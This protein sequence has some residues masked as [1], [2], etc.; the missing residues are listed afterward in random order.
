MR[1][2]DHQGGN[3]DNTANTD[4]DVQR[5]KEP[6]EEEDSVM[7]PDVWIPPMWEDILHEGDVLQPPD[8]YVVP[9]DYQPRLLRNPSLRKLSKTLCNIL[10]WTAKRIGLDISDQ[11]WVDVKKLLECGRLASTT[12]EDLWTICETDDKRRFEMQPTNDGRMRIRATNGHGIPGV[13]ALARKLLPTDKV[14]WVVHLTNWCAVQHIAREGLKRFQRNHIH[15][16]G[17]PPTEGETVAGV[18]HRVDFCVYVDAGRAIDDGISFW[19]TRNGVIVSQGDQHGKI[20]LRYIVKIVDKDTGRQYFPKEGLPPRWRTKHEGETTVQVHNSTERDF[21]YYAWCKFGNDAQ[22]VLM[23]VDTGASISIIPAEIYQA[24]PEEERPTLQEVKLRIEVGNGETLA[25]QGV[26]RIKFQLGDF[27]F[28]H[29]F[30]VCKDS[31]QAILGNE[32]LVHYRMVLRMAEGWLEYR[33]HC[34]PLFNWV[35]ARHR[36]KVFL[37]KTVQVPPHSEVEVPTEVRRPSIPG[38]PQVFEPNQ[39]LLRKANMIAPRMLF[40]PRDEHPRVRLFNP[41]DSPV[42]ITV[43]RCLGALEDAEDVRGSRRCS[44]AVRTHSAHSDESKEHGEE[45]PGELPTAGEQDHTT[46]E[47]LLRGTFEKYSSNIPEHMAGLVHTATEN[48]PPDEAMRVTLLLLSFQDVFARHE[49]DIGRTTLITHDVDTGDAKPVAQ[50]VRRQSP[51]EHAAMVDIVQTLHKCGIIQPSKSQWAANIRMARKKDKKWRMCIDYRDLNKR[52][53]I[54]DPYPLPRI[55]ALLD[56]LGRGTVFCALDLISGYHQVSMTRR[57]Q[58]KSAFITPQMSPSHW[59]YK[60]MP[61]GLTGAPATFQRLVD[62]M[63]RGIQYNTV[64]AYLDDIIVIGKDVADCRN[65]LAEVLSRIRGA[66]LKLKPSKCEL[67]KDRIT[68]LG[69][70]VSGSGVQ[71]DPKKVRLVRDWPVPLYITDVRG[72]LGFCNYYRKFVKGYI[73]LARPLNKLLCKDSDLVW[74]KEQ[75]SAFNAL[76]AALT[77]APMLAHPREDCQYILDTDA[78]AYGIGGVL[79]QLQPASEGQLEERPIAFHGRLL[80]PREMRY[81]TRR[82]EFLAIYEMVEYF[83]CYLS[84]RSFTIR[85]DH[86]SLKGVKQLDK[87]TG[88][89]ARWI[90]YLE[91][92]QFKVEVRPGNLHSNADFLSRLYTDCFCK[93]REEFTST[94]SAEEALKN[95]PIKD[96]ALFEKCC[97]EQADRR[98]RDKRSEMLHIHD[99]D[100]LRT[101]SDHDLKEQIEIAAKVGGDEGRAQLH[102]IST[103]RLLPHGMV[104][105]LQ[106]EVFQWQPIW[107]REEMQHH[108]EHD[109]DLCEVFRAKSDPDGEKPN[110]SDITFEDLGAKYYINEWSRLKIINGLLYRL[111]ESAD[112]LT[113]WY[114]LVIPTVYQQDLIRNVHSTWVG[115]HQGY[116][117]TWEYIRRRFFW[118]EMS[119][120]IRHLIRTCEACQRRKN[121]NFTPKWPMQLYG[122]GFRNE[123]V[124]LDM[125]GPIK[126]TRMPFTYLLIVCDV[127]TKYVVA[128]PLKTSEAKEIMQGF[129]DRWC[130][131]FGFPYHIHSDQG[132]NLTGEL[133]RELCT[134]LRIERTRTTPYRPQANGQNERTNRTIVELLRTTQERHEDW[135]LRVSHVCFSYNST[136]HAATSFSPHYLM[137]GC[138]PYS[139]LDVR[140]PTG[141]AILPLPVNEHAERIVEHMS[142]AHVAA[143]NHLRTAAE[144]RKR[145]YDRDLGENGQSRKT[146]QFVEGERVLIRVSDHHRHFGKLNDRYVGPYYIVTVFPTGTVRVKKGE[147]HP[148]RIVHHDKLR[149]FYEDVV[150]PTPHWVEQSIELFKRREEERKARRAHPHE[151]GEA[152]LESTTGPRCNKCGNPEIDAQ[153]IFRTVNQNGLCQLCADTEEGGDDEELPPLED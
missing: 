129:L 97:R 87:L 85:T 2:A 102:R 71:T 122:V 32:F 39:D 11:G 68:Y 50:A 37:R 62:T 73:D 142:D 153:G 90:D 45:Q 103:V 24:I 67:F 25:Q 1:K 127:F 124:T 38:R 43:N 133:W 14:G 63:L 53:L 41:N 20:P 144:T 149:R 104:G 12:V 78:S 123:R 7:E 94:R 15:F 64:L 82:R 150:T 29:E 61:F 148:P 145:Y 132:S 98:V 89:M 55:D 49:A 54:N 117:R 26:C 44:A 136:P 56:T 48:L 106:E 99:E 119:R 57:A 35:G 46:A 76:K 70:I 18:R 84:G 75:T 22:D 100:A 9:L 23:L 86:D 141:P 93:P 79:S 88:Q 109:P 96:F 13:N 27:D 139:D 28:D 33:G 47:A 110:W 30:F 59:E 111:W 91:G 83:R 31:A 65:N 10:R 60:Y 17:R 66:N 6:A 137:F 138:E 105:D 3:K 19:V 101:L 118:F 114:Q 120:H 126:F 8:A 34:I 95:E 152:L 146:R 128:V 107:T 134:L 21:A 151:E 74:R 108:Q 52:T 143:R 58:E 81:C 5:G 130:N 40:D 4:S 125:C 147:N 36:S 51:E 92:Y 72:F 131:V 80:L 69:H 16:V 135:H 121:S 113:E 77:E 116:R 115:S 140:T 42:W 112:G